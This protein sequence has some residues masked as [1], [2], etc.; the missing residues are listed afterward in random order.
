MRAL[1]GARC[2]GVR[3]YKKIDTRTRSARIVK[4]CRLFDFLHAG[5]FFTLL[6]SYSDI[7]QKSFFKNA[8]RVSNRLDPDKDHL[9][10]DR[11]KLFT[12]EPQHEI[13]NN[14]VCATSKGSDQSAHTR[15]LVR[16]FAS[17]LNIL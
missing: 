1:S 6:L 7:F 16:A 13:S 3:L 8:V 12:N 14:V 2:T 17:H 9:I 15:S 5:Q 4:H 10:W 11:C